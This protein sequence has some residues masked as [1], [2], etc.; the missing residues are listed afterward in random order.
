MTDLPRNLAR[1]TFLADLGRVTLGA[2]VLGPVLAGCSDG[3]DGSQ[4]GPDPDSGT[5]ADDVGGAGVLEWQRASFGFVSA[6]VLE[7]DGEALVFD[8]GTG[9]DIAA[10]TAALGAAG[11]G[12]GDVGT[13]LVSHDHGDHIGGVELIAAEAPDAVFRA[14]MPD[15]DSLRDRVEAAE[16]VADGAT[17][18]AD[19]QVVATPGHTLGHVSAYDRSTELL[20]AGDAIVN[21]V[22]IG[23]TSGE[24]IEASPPEFTADTE[25]ALASVGVLADLRPAAIVFGHGEP[26]T[27]GAADALADYAATL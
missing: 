7:R 5:A 23:G 9:D 8:T 13:V 10:I 6:Y 11:V 16:E 21:G 24:G 19:L 26:V 3:D 18:L 14:A 22:S 1:R 4:Q 15:L 12:W 27:D 2:V 17:L 20:L 25:Q